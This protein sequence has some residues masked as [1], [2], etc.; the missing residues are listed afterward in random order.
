M[1]ALFPFGTFCH[2]LVDHRLLVLLLLGEDLLV[3][4]REDFA[5]GD[6]SEA[7]ALLMVMV[8][9]VIMGMIM[10]VG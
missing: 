1:L 6:A 8:V 2:F 5:V 9:G 7:L 3:P 10:T 4:A